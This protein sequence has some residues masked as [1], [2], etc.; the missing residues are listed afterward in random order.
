MYTTRSN[1]GRDEKRFLEGICMITT[2]DMEEMRKEANAILESDVFKKRG[3]RPFLKAGKTGCFNRGIQLIHTPFDLC[4]DIVA[5]LAESVDIKKQQIGV[6]FNLEFVDVLINDF[7]VRPSQITFMAD[8]ITKG[9]ASLHWYNIQ[10]TYGITYDKS[11]KKWE[12]IEIMPKHGKQFDVVIMNPPYNKPPTK[13][14]VGSGNFLW[15]EFVHMVLNNL[16][17]EGGYL[18]AIHPPKWR[19]P[20]DELFPVLT[21][22]HMIHLSMYR[23]SDKLFGK[24]VS[25]PAD[26][27]VMK[28]EPYKGQ[29]VVEYGDEVVKI[30]ISKLPFIPNGNLDVLKRIL[31][32][33]EEPRCEILSGQRQKDVPANVYDTRRSTVQKEK[34]GKFK[35]PLVNGTGKEGVNFFYCSVKG[36]YFGVAKVIFCDANDLGN[37]IL[38]EEGKYGMTQHGIAIPITTKEEGEQ[39]VQALESIEWNGFLKSVTYGGFQISPKMFKYF[40]A[41]FWKEFV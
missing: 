1:H 36:P 37:I 18:A 23:G 33:G 7:G 14:K 24:S 19:K 13:E 5:K 16:L 4:H 2:Q 28:K 10:N 40:R 21:G 29:T 22:H 41:D 27:Y 32:N 17:R 3:Y 34:S 12:R 11:K 30:D 9:A 31:A 20:E 15:P 8:D 38:D 25:T 26:W 39:I 35:Y 6:L